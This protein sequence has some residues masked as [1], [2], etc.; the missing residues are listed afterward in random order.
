MVFN[1]NFLL[2]IITIL[3]F[4][5]G[6]FYWIITERIANREMP[7]TNTEGSIKLY[8]RIR[9][10]ILPLVEII[11]ILQLFGLQIFPLPEQSFIIQ[12]LGFILVLIGVSIAIFARKT[13]GVNW[14]PAA[15]Y[16]VK[17]RQR[18]V[19]TGIYAYIRHPIYLSVFLSITGGELVAQ[20]YL[21]AM[22]FLFLA[23]GYKQSYCEEK[24]LLDHFGNLYKTYMKRTKMFIPYLW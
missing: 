17:Q 20:S 13:L 12:S 16:Q 9:R 24:L 10:L 4:L 2:R 23:E 5:S 8:Q 6:R 22:G 1:L 18:L 15:E 14:V 7:K 3:L 19:T 21:L 11:L